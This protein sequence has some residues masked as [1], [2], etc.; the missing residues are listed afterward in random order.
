[1]KY[2]LK[3]SFIISLYLP[4]VIATV[5]QAAPASSFVVS[6]IGSFFIFYQTWFSSLR[7][8]LPDRPIERQIMRPLFLQ[9]LI[10]AG[11]MCCTSIFYFADSMGYKYFEQTSKI[12]SAA[13]DDALILIAKC[14]RLSVLGH[15]ALVT[16]FLLAQRK[17][18]VN[19][20]VYR[21]ATHTSIE[22]WTV[23]VGLITLILS[24]AF[25]RISGLFQFSIGL[26]NVTIF[27][28]AVTLVKGIRN[29]NLILMLWG[30]GVFVLNLAV[31]SLSGYKEPLIVNSIILFCLLYPHYKREVAFAVIPFFLFLFYFAPTYSTVIRKQSWSGDRT[32]EDARQE[33]LETLLNEDS[34][35]EET[36]WSFLTGRLSEI[37]MFTKFVQTTPDIIPYYNFDIAS[38]AI[39]SIV[40]RALWKDKPITEEIAMERV[41]DAGVVDDRSSVS[42]KA[43]P[44]V[45]AYLSGG[46]IGIIIY[47]IF[48]GF[49]SQSLCTKA[50]SLFGG[51]EIGCVIFFNG[52][53][54]ILWRGE[55]TEFMVN[56]VFWSF[57]AMIL[58]WLGLRL[59]NFLEKINPL[60][61]TK[62]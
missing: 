5:I 45:D 57:I 53:F 2:P 34:S 60:D 43:R 27:C 33:A 25:E 44:I 31:A 24:L 16:G 61:Y 30:G 48:L 14:Q 58:L 59:T 26:Y 40:P 7:F 47:M 12:D 11:F 19:P 18:T 4:W 51:Y 22:T 39:I 36:N 54:Q 23:R 17:T 38:N 42:A 55:S 9:Q 1:M 13:I 10:F 21:P 29:K 3:T 46:L 35:L 49:I 52:F 32:A 37:G 41:Y 28:G 56:S 15:A 6:W 50:E 20:A 8:I 62:L